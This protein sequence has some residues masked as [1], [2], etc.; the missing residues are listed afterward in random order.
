MFLNKHIT[1]LNLK[2]HNYSFIYIISNFTLHID[3]F[4]LQ[5]IFFNKSRTRDDVVFRNNRVDL[6]CCW[7]ASTLNLHRVQ[8]GDVPLTSL[9][10]EVCGFELFDVWT[11]GQAGSDLFYDGYS[12]ATKM[13]KIEE[14]S[15]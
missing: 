10:V 7:Q 9:H 6:E 15:R 8:N 11:N 14:A 2:L 4:L 13:L 5:S 1:L 12:D 3:C